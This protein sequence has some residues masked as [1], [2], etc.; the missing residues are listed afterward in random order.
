V[1]G[2]GCSERYV[3]R[4][5]KSCGKKG[6]A[7][8]GVCGERGMPR[9][10]GNLREVQMRRCLAVWGERQRFTGFQA[11]HRLY[12]RKAERVRP[13]NVRGDGGTVDGNPDW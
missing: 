1:L 4:C 8:E 12:R 13:Q 6:S 5:G 2:E 3:E 10:R 7:R 9:P 11:S